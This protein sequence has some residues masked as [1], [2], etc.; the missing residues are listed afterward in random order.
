MGVSYLPVS[1]IFTVLSITT[2]HYWTEP[3]LTEL[4]SDG[5]NRNILLHPEDVTHALE[6]LLLSSNSTIALVAN[7]V[8]NIYLLIILSLKGM[9]LPLVVP[10][11][12]IQVGSWSTWLIV[13]SSLKMFQALAR[14]RLQSLNSS[15]S[16]TPRSYFRVYCVLLLVISVDVV[17]YI[18]LN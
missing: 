12:V 15:P 6:L 9:F 8:I 11:T 5:L 14:D 17:W 13:V 1:A 4:K 18:G 16:A 3:S 10:P 2:L 7:F